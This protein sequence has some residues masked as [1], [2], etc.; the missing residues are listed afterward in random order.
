M[1]EKEAVTRKLRKKYK[2]AI[3]AQKGEIID[4]LVEV[5]VYNRKYAATLLRKGVKKKSKPNKPKPRTVDHQNTT[6]KSS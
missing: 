4:W 6:K 5:A 3:K 2:R 1:K